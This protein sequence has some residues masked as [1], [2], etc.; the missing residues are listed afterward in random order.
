MKSFAP[1]R[2]LITGCI[3]VIALF[4]VVASERAPRIRRVES[5]DA[6]LTS[7]L[8]LLYEE[9]SL[10]GTKYRIMKP[11]D[12]DANRSYPLIL[13][14]HGAGG[15]GNNNY[16]QLRFWNQVMATR[17]WRTKYPCFVLTPQSEGLWYLKRNWDVLSDDQL[18]SL[19]RS[20]KMVA[21]IYRLKQELGVIPEGGLDEA[22][23]VLDHVVERYNIDRKRIYVLGA[24]MGGY[25]SWNAIANY[26]ETFAAAVPVCGGWPQ[27]KSID[28]VN[29]IPVWAF[30]GAKDRVIKPEKARVIFQRLKESRGNMKYTEFADTG[31]SSW[32]RAFTFNGD[33]TVEGA[34]TKYSSDKC[35]KTENIWDWLFRQKKPGA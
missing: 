30:H 1:R 3:S 32:I 17:D 20:H 19:S 35:D 26:P 10:G 34:V 21:D 24:S 4:Q 28:P 23:A 14:L 12:H 18:L 31:H 11:I 22:M 9:D 13:S 15:R 8:R 5:R 2:T 33:R 25:G 16:S 7:D 29:D 6:S 27:R